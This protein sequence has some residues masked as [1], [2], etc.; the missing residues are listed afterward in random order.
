MSLRWTR[1]AYADLV[2]IVEFLEPVNPAAAG[3][4][5][6]TIVA[7][8]R[9][10]ASHPRLG[11]VLPRYQPREVRHVFVERYEI[12]YELAGNDVYVLRVFHTREDR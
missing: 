4:V 6:R 12:R 5:A 10:I 1:Q 8:V 2:R 3:R 7:R 11:A 9:R